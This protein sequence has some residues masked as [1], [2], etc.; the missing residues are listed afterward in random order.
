MLNFALVLLFAFS[1]WA[2]PGHDH[3]APGAVEAPKG[4]M[5]KSLEETHVELVH[6]GT[7]LRIYLYDLNMKIKDP[8]QFKLTATAELPRS[9]KG[10]VITFAVKD[11]ALVGQYDA[12]GTHRY[13]LKLAILDPSTGHN[14]R[15][16]FIVEPRK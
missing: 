6:K 14:D 11:G 4:G 5:I 16:D 1:T 8:T 9:K 13:T 10:E 15:M 7:E 3:N 12:K 2:H